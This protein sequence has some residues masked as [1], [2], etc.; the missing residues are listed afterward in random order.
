MRKSLLTWPLLACCFGSHAA[1][2]PPDTGKPCEIS[3]ARVLPSGIAYRLELR[4][5]RLDPETY[6]KR[7]PSGFWGADGDYPATRVT[8][9]S[10]VLDNTDIGIPAKIYTDLGNIHAAEIKRAEMLSMTLNTIGGG[11]GLVLFGWISMALH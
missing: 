1:Q 8:S 3:E 11:L 4:E 2:C 6:G 5:A 10:V 9:L 7:Y